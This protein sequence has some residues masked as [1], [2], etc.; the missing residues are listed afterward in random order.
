MC[1]SYAAGL[2]PVLTVVSDES[3]LFEAA[4]CR[5][6][7]SPWNLEAVGEFARREPEFGM[8]CEVF[9]DPSPVRP[10]VW[11]VTRLVA[12]EIDGYRSL[13]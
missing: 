5:P 12:L 2:R 9:E 13:L 8:L 7:T 4:Q 11:Q 1:A 10:V 3:T 6:N